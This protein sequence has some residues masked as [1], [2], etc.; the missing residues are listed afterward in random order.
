[1]APRTGSG[2]VRQMSRVPRAGVHADPRRF[3]QAHIACMRPTPRRSGLIRLS[4]RNQW[5][6]NA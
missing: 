4:G 3:A 6:M 1:M 2:L 5:D